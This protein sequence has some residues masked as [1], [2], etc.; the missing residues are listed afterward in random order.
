MLIGKKI[1]DNT[2]IDELIDK[3]KQKKELKEISEEFV[4][5]QLY[6][7]LKSNP[8]QVS[9]L[10]NK[11]S[12]YYKIIVKEIREKLRR[13]YGLFRVEEEKKKRDSLFE[14]L[15][16]E[17]ANKNIN[18]NNNN[19]DDGDNDN[20]D[21]IVKILKTHASTKERLPY[22]E[23]LYDKIWKITKKPKSIID[24]GCGINPFSF[25]FMNLKNVKLFVYDI[26]N[27]EI[28][29]LNKYFGFLHEKNNHFV[30]KAFT[31]DALNWR[32]IPKADVC[33]LFK[34]TDVLDR[35]KGHK[36]SELVIS[37][38]PT[39]FVVVSFPTLT[40]SGKKMNYP[41]RKW[42]ELMCDRLEYKYKVIEY[43]NEIFYVIEK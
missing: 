32:K 22:Y 42:I 14:N 35:G 30:G 12:K 41:R 24:L 37:N 21:I 38:I 23:K 36:S 10:D 28:D 26:S 1:I 31:L 2:L 39:K 43:A 19:K 9:Y 8:K 7:Y 33:F 29:I 18:N 17:N 3:I 16:K 25:V 20:K 27:D 40:M 34:M 11:N 4:K 5:D 15:L 6:S 13:V